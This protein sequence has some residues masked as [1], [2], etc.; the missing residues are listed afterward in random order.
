MLPEEAAVAAPAEDDFVVRRRP[1]SAETLSAE[2]VQWLAAL[3]PSVKP[4]LLP[5]EFVRIANALSRRWGTPSACLAYFD[6]LLINKR[7]PRR[8]FSIGIV[9]ELAGLKNYFQTFVHPA[10]QTV[11]DEVS[12]RSREGQK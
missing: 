8:G 9:L 11:W 4:T 12:K 6:D 2:T 3:P 5:I 10:P 7:G 1:Q